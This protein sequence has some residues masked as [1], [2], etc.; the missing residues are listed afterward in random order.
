MALTKYPHSHSALRRRRSSRSLSFV[1]ATS[2][3]VQFLLLNGQFL[4]SDLQFGRVLPFPTNFQ[5]TLLNSAGLLPA[6]TRACGRSS[7][8]INPCRQLRSR[9]RE[10]SWAFLMAGLLFTSE[11]GL[12]LVSRPLSQFGRVQTFLG[13][14]LSRARRNETLLPLAWFVSAG[15]ACWCDVQRFFLAAKRV[16]FSLHLVALLQLH[17]NGGEFCSACSAG[18]SGF[19]FV[20]LPLRQQGLLVEKPHQLGIVFSEMYI[21]PFWVAKSKI[22]ILIMHQHGLIVGIM[23]EFQKQNKFPK[24]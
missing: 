14:Q 4:S 18:P 12:L 1:T 15:A 16:L 19:G 23:Y 8:A 11:F 17:F 5:L 3:H 10:L 24:T 22:G 20:R 6:M 7:S 2:L 9:C 21:A 13:L